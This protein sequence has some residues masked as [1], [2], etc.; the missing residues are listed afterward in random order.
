MIDIVTT[1]S[2]A[3]PAAKRITK[4]D[5][6][7]KALQRKSGADIPI[8]SRSF[9]WQPHS[10]RAALTGLRKAGFLI[11]KTAADGKRKAVY[12]IVDQSAGNDVAAAA[13]Q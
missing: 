11:E 1:T 12:R 3:A 6:L 2:K 13:S 9:G 7:I 4:R 8:L 10:T 5:Q